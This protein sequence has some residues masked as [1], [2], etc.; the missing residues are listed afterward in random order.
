LKSKL[1]LFLVMMLVVLMFVAVGCGEADVPAEGDSGDEPAAGDD[2]T[3][4][5]FLPSLEFT[6]FSAMVDHCAATADELGITV[7]VIDGENSQEKQV[8]DIED[9]ITMGVDGMVIIPITAE[10][11][12]LAIQAAMDAGIPVVTVDRTSKVDVVAHVGADFT[13]QGRIAARLFIEGLEA[14]YPDLEQ[15]DIVEV[16]GTPGASATTDRGAGM[17]EIFN[18]DPRINIVAALTGEF[19]T[20]GGRSVAEDQLTANPGLHGILAHNDMMGHGVIE[21]AREAGVL[22]QLVIVAID[23]QV[24][25][26]QEVLNGVAYATVSHDPYQIVAG[27]KA[28]Y[29][30]I[31]GEEV[32]KLVLLEA[33]AIKQEDAQEALDSGM[34][35]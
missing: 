16:Q 3:I 1:S 5:V 15:W 30:Y 34:A 24:S 28:V 25:F 9:A 13:E 19:T 8:R 14:K 20:T 31:N 26:V 11:A 10:G 35:F 12:N 21:A 32:E 22:D 7:Q 17:N 29:D 4:A 6:F 27:I 23:G 18:A 2:L 33:D